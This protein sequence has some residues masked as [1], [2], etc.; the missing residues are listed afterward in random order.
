MLNDKNTYS[1]HLN[2][3]QVNSIKPHVFVI[4]LLNI[5]ILTTKK[6]KNII[7]PNGY[8]KAIINYV[9]YLHYINPVASLS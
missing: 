7:T 9:K 8:G 1:C 6:Y 5:L 3:I 4:K 2:Y